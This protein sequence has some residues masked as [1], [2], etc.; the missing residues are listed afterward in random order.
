MYNGKEWEGW[1]TNER[2]E[3]SSLIS[4]F[5][6]ICDYLP[7]VKLERRKF[8]RDE[9]PFSGRPSLSVHPGSLRDLCCRQCGRFAAVCRI[10]SGSGWLGRASIGVGRRFAVAVASK[11]DVSSGI[12]LTAAAAAG[13]YGIA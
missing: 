3:K 10:D 4:F 12:V 13:A 7:D 1:H 11:S 5:V 8:E 2:K 6:C 9:G